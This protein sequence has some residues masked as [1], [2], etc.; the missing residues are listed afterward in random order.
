[1]EWE[2]KKNHTLGERQSESRQ[3]LEKYPDRVPIIVQKVPSSTLPD[4]E[5]GKFLQPDDLTIAQFMYIVRKRINLPPEQTMFLFIQKR[6][7]E[8]SIT[9]QV[10]YDGNKDEDGFLYIAYSGENTFLG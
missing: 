4:I 1:M 8:T 6:L 3:I 7:P 5:K 10:V 9:L 2:F